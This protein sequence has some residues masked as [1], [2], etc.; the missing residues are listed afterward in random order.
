MSTFTARAA[1]IGTLAGVVA[2]ITTVAGIIAI[3]DLDIVGKIRD[4]N[5]R[6]GLSPVERA[7]LD[8]YRRAA[9]AH[10][11][12]AI[13]DRDKAEAARRARFAPELLTVATADRLEALSVADLLTEHGA[14]VEQCHRAAQGADADDFNKRSGH[15]LALRAEV[16]RRHE[17]QVR[18]K[19]PE[20]DRLRI[21]HGF[22][23]IHAAENGQIARVLSNNF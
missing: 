13:D 7:E 20:L 4:A 16:A 9:A 22:T 3:D 17:Y 19:L 23:A 11:R 5:Y 12:A 10:D 14:A 15:A 18:A 6:R 2:G 21:E 1:A 8:R